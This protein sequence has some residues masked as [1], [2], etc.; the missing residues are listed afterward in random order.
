[1]R[2]RRVASLLTVAAALVGTSDRLPA[3]ADLLSDLLTR[4]ISLADS[5]VDEVRRG[6]PV[7]VPLE[8]S[9]S[10]EI[11]I[12]AA[13]RIAAPASRVV[14]LV[15]DI[16]RLEQGEGV[17]ATRKF[18]SPPVEADMAQFRWPDVD[19][20]ALPSCRP[21]RCDVKLG[22]SALQAVAA[23]DWNAAT[24]AAEA[25]RLMRRMGV[26]Y[27]QRYR[28]GGNASLAVYQDAAR[29]ISVAGE[30]EDMV[31][32]SSGLKTVPEVAAYLL[33]YPRARPSGVQDFFY[34]SLAEFGLKPVLRLN[35]VVIHQTRRPSGLQYA[36]TTKQ[37]YASHY[38]HTALEVRM[39]VDDAERP[40][41]SHYLVVLN[42]GRSD[43]FDGLLGGVVKG[44]ARAGALDGISKAV[45]AMKRLAER[46]STAP[47]RTR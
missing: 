45:M 12:G 1:M 17:H 43:G 32:R 38:F 31:S 10:S 9:V 25:N 3:R 4:H 16:E 18:S 27:I 21:G 39:L 2:S 24:A 47:A 23:I 20:A 34:W 22:T 35:H 6:Q 29:P 11:A 30:F 40:G 15:R 7:V 46:P 37:L 26:E 28:T 14:A 41:R 36:I 33:Q 42:V 8:T 19:L 5:Q 13:V 44:K